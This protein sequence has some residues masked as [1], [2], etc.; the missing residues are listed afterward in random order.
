VEE[1]L[2][3]EGELAV[4]SVGISR[5]LR[6]LDGHELVAL[7]FGD[8]ETVVVLAIPQRRPE[9]DRVCR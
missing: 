7:R 4:V 8:D 9:P 6:Y 3:V 2:A 5:S 1:A